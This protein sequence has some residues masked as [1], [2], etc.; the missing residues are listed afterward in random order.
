MG[1]QKIINFYKLLFT[2]IIVSFTY[3]CLP[4]KKRK[5]QLPSG[6]L[7]TIGKGIMLFSGTRIKYIKINM[8]S[9]VSD[10]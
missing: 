7:Y 3:Y 6:M 10:T 4:W 8:H 9:E 5:V 1:E 2:V